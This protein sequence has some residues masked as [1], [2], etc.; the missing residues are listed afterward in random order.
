MNKKT[1]PHRI[2][3]LGWLLM[4]A[5]A[6][7]WGGSFVANRQALTGLPVLT[8][9]AIRVGGGALALWLW[10]A[11]RG[12][13]VPRGAR[14]LAACAG[15]G[16]FNNILPFTLIVW[17]QQQIPAGLAG[18]LNA[19]T[20][21]F[22]V[23]AAAAVF[24]DERLTLPRLVGVVLGLAGV[25]VAIGPAALAGFDLRSAAQLACLG[26]ALSYAVSG[27]FGRIMLQGVRPEVSA[28]GMLTAASL[29]LVPAALMVDGLPVALPDAATLAALAYLALAASAVAY[30]LFYAVLT[31]AG[32]GNLGLVTLLVAPVAIVLGALLFGERL[33]A[34][35][36][37][38][39]G[40]I[41]LG[42]AVL[43]GRIPLPKRFSA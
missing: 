2:S 4:A 9:V 36:L 31:L 16:M 20:A 7:I 15:M 43:D 19:S 1:L 27:A 34:G 39:F 14:W 6:L 22:G 21:V 37:A 25:V 13:P 11:V 18:I 40:L 33:S 29:V 12:L 38:G 23:L 10:I 26:A 35:A 28:A 17:G 3:P 24:A 5:L 41:A 30:I 42:L 8:I 32:A